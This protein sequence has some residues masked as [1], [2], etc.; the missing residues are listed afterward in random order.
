[1]SAVRRDDGGEAVGVLAAV[2]QFGPFDLLSD[3]AFEQ[4]QVGDR[5]LAATTCRKYLVVSL[6]AGDEPTTRYLMY[7]L[8]RAL[9]EL[10][11]IDEA[12]EVI[13]ALG[14]RCRLDPQPYWRAKVSVVRS[15][16]VRRSDD[17]S[18]VVEHVAL[19]S[20]LTGI[21]DGAVYNQVSAAVVLAEGLRSLEMFAEAERILLATLRVAR[22]EITRLGVV[23]D[24]AR[25]LA[26]WA[27]RLLMVG[28]TAQAQ[29]VCVELLTRSRLLARLDV[30]GVHRP[31]TLVVEGFAW[32]VLGEPLMGLD[33]I[34]RARPGLRPDRVECLMAMAAAALAH[35]D[36]GAV[37]AA[38]READALAAVAKV[39]ERALWIQ[40][41][42]WLRLELSLTSSVPPASTVLAARMLREAMRELWG[43]RAARVES[44]RALMRVHE[45]E[46]ENERARGLGRT[47]ALTGVGNRRALTERLARA[48]G[49][50]VAMFVD[51]DRFKEVNDRR[52]HVVGDEALVHVARLLVELAPPAA[53]V[54]R[55]GGDEFVTV[56][57][58]G[59]EL[60]TAEQLADKVSAA[61]REREW[62]RI[63]DDFELTLSYGIAV[64]PASTILERLSRAVI[65]AKRSGR[66]QRVTAAD[67][68]GGQ[69]DRR[70]ARADRRA[71]PMDRRVTEALA[72]SDLAT[73]DGAAV[74]D[75]RAA[76]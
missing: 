28:L 26:E 60:E 44:V 30:R 18:T 42:E 29:A 38:A 54:A 7:A 15:F 22:E 31:L 59:A 46:A 2:P 3:I 70:T 53:L 65:S 14:E 64:G 69:R 9:T 40:G 55:F 72:G 49:D 8:G 67:R 5:A 75:A 41:G 25:T 21:P 63:A 24:L 61:L 50:V 4:Y 58:P 11:F 10:G 19:G 6:A 51:L 35:S 32:V 13:D 71:G 33:M 73:D 1:M 48:E 45:L 27:M 12:L 62:A 17:P 76:T 68:R 39:S 36:L 74:G 43:E 56:L 20:V 57:G 23:V 37:D 34:E 66:D 52:S 47:D 16:A